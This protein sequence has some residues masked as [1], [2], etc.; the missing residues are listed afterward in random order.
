MNAVDIA[1]L[2]DKIRLVERKMGLVYTLFKASVYSVTMQ[3]QEDEAEEEEGYNEQE[4]GLVEDN[5]VRQPEGRRLS[6]QSQ[7]QNQGQSQSQE[8]LQDLFQQQDDSS[9]LFQL[10]QRPLSQQGYRP[11]LL[12]QRRS[13]F[14]NNSSGLDYR[15]TNRPVIRMSNANVS[16]NTREDYPGRKSIM[17]LSR[18]Q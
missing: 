8:S 4:Q 17:S 2:I 10:Q 7:I 16:A 12:P 9:P 1:Q 15:N 18:Y 11:S 5:S 13:L 14:S 3:S 6:Q